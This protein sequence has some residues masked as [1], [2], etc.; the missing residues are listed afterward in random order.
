MLW[1]HTLRHLGP[2]LLLRLSNVVLTLLSS[3]ALVIEFFFGFAVVEVLAY[4]LVHRASHV[5][6]NL[7]SDGMAGASCDLWEG[8]NLLLTAPSTCETRSLGKV[9]QS[10]FLTPGDFVRL[11]RFTVA[12]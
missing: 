6:S 5:S 1:S 3:F 7:R 11:S 2:F 4:S 12:P 10:V 9:I 8:V